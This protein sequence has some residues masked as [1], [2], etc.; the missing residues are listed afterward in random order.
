[1]GNGYEW[2]VSLSLSEAFP[3]RRGI[4]VS[5]WLNDMWR[6]TPWVIDSGWSVAPWR[7]CFVRRWRVGV[8]TRGSGPFPGP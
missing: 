1:M 6:W 3:F 8:E 7:R 4:H 2:A 5:T